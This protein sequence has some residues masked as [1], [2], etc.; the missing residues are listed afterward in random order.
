M[1]TTAGKSPTWTKRQAVA[2]DGNE[3]WWCVRYDWRAMSYQALCE[4]CGWESEPVLEI[5]AATRLLENHLLSDE[6]RCLE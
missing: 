3:L 6:H 2:D 1:W 4:G 5:G